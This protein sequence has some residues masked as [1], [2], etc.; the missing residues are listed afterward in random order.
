M[1]GRQGGG[2]NLRGTTALESLY[3]G[4]KPGINPGIS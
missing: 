1:E 3:A 4:V 2:S